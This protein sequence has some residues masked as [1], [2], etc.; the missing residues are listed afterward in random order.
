MPTKTVFL[1]EEHNLVDPADSV[2]VVNTKTDEKGHVLEERWERTVSVS[3]VPTKEG[4]LLAIYESIDHKKKAQP[5]FSIF[6]IVALILLALSSIFA[7]V[8]I[9]I[10]VTVPL[11][12]I[13]LIAGIAA[14]KQ[15]VQQ[16]IIE[17][18]D[19]NS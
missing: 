4:K 3:S 13:G 14:I 9:P 15:L 19:N 18:K 10:F 11:L 8:G 5:P 17:D 7:I 1:D 6:V 12:I 16:N 2:F